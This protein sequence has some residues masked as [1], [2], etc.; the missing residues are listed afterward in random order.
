[1][2]ACPDGVTPSQGWAGWRGSLFIARAS[3]IERVAQGPV[4]LPPP[5]AATGLRGTWLPG[6]GCGHQRP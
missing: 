1:M 3:G 2:L 4:H 5:A 6:T